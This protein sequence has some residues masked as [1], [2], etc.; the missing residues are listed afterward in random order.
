MSKSNRGRSKISLHPR[1][2]YAMQRSGSMNPL[3]L[4]S[5]GPL[6]DTL[7]SVALWRPL[8]CNALHPEGVDHQ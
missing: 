2:E 7:N 4:S 6:S 8:K 5:R 1:G 3:I